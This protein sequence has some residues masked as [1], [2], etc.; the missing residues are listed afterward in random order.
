M[1]SD[2]IS[3]YVKIRG[4]RST[5][6]ALVYSTATR[7]LRKVHWIQR[8]P[9]PLATAHAAEVAHSGEIRVAAFAEDDDIVLGFALLAQK[10]IDLVWVKSQ[11]RR[12]GIGRLLI[13]DRIDDVCAYPLPC[14]F[15]PRAWVDD[16][17][18]AMLE[19]CARRVGMGT[20]PCPHT[21][22]GQTREGLCR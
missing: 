1:T 14:N 22:D 4:L 15:A 9:E 10:R 16:Y 13:Y 11:F 2:M 18:Q 5:D 7:M 3:E 20:T 12:R 6:E 19:D 17:G 21:A 8:L